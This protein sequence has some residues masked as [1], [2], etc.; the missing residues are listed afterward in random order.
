MSQAEGLLCSE[1]FN[2]LIN[3]SGDVERQGLHIAL[4][5]SHAD[6]KAQRVLRRQ[7][8]NQFK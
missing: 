3:N 4:R 7:K 6:R 2:T 8:A 5:G 1:D